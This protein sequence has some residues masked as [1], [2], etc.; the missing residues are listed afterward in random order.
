MEYLRS[1]WAENHSTKWEMWLVHSK[2]EIPQ[3]NSTNGDVEDNAK[4]LFFAG[5][6][7]LKK[8]NEDVIY[9]SQM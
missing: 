3:Q 1:V 4:Y 9:I 2:L 5:K 7:V 6:S 8:S